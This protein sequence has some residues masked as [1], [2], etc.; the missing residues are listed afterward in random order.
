VVDGMVENSDKFKINVVR[1][2]FAHFLYNRKIDDNLGKYN[3]NTVFSSG[4]VI[5]KDDKIILGKMGKHT[6]R[7]GILQFSGGGLENGDLREDGI[8]DMRHSLEKEIKEELGIDL[9]DKKR[10]KQTKFYCTKVGGNGNIAI[11]YRV[12]L[13]ETI[14]EFKQRYN[15]F[16]TNLQKNKKAEFDEIVAVSKDRKIIEEFIDKNINKMVDYMPNV[17]L[18]I[19]K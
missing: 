6:S 16:V 12:D 1:T 15:L 9:R 14:D 7:A 5:T 8:F 13:E 10:I 2:S 3:I 18:E 17:L 19:V 11:I 4:L